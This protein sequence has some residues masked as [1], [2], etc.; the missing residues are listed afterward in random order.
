MSFETALYSVLEP[1]VADVLKDATDKILREVPLVEKTPDRSELRGPDRR[2]SIGLTKREGKKIATFLVEKDDSWAMQKAMEMQESFPVPLAVTVTGKAHSYW[3]QDALPQHA[4]YDLCPG[5]SI[6]HFSGFAGTLG[7]LVLVRSRKKEWISI[8]SASHVLSMINSA[9]KDDPIIL[10]GFPDGH[11]TLSN[12]IGVVTDFT[13]L[14]HHQNVVVQTRSVNTEDVAVAKL[15]NQENCPSVNLVPNPK[16][17]DEKIKLKGCLSD[18]ELIERMQEPVFKVGRTTSFT[19]G[20]FDAVT[21]TPH[22]IRLPDRKVYLY[23]NTLVVRNKG[24]KA[25]SLHGDSGSLVYTADGKGVGLI[26]GA[27]NR[28]TYLSPL[29]SSLKV[30][31]A[32]LLT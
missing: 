7:C 10:P 15:D 31:K 29:H 13:F 12:K 20:I 11:R 25:F 5:L 21:T 28:T 26:I 1:V 6:S 16:N 2:L 22:S 9:Q 17:P 18:E 19:E 23:K 14:V 4:P 3:P 30:M 24:K 27:S 32:T 8:A